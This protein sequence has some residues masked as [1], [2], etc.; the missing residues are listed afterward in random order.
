MEQW[1]QQKFNDITNFFVLFS[2][3]DRFLNSFLFN[4]I[5]RS[6]RFF[7]FRLSFTKLFIHT[8]EIH[9]LWH[10]DKSVRDDTR[11]TSHIARRVCSIFGFVWTTAIECLL[12][13]QPASQPTSNKMSTKTNKQS[14]TDSHWKTTP[15]TEWAHK[16]YWIER[17]KK[18]LINK[19][20]WKE[21]RCTSAQRKAIE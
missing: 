16:L 10:C 8:I 2:F 6:S 13:S 1:A 15:C 9:N 11:H 18:T 4:F 17:Q 5:F 20:D 7:Y 3:L 12:T 14:R 21:R 19:F